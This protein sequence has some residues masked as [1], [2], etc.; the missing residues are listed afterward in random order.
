MLRL[1]SAVAMALFIASGVAQAAED[2]CAA[3]LLPNQTKI[4]ENAHLAVSM[5]DLITEDN[6]SKAKDTFGASFPIAEVPFGADFSSFNES[7]RKYQEL[8]KYDLDYERSYNYATSILGNDQVKAWGECMVGKEK[9]VL[10]AAASDDEKEYAIVQV[11]YD[12]GVA[13]YQQIPISFAALNGE[14][15]GMKLPKTIP[16]RISQEIVISRKDLDKDIVFQVGIGATSRT[17]RIPPPPPPPVAPIC[18]AIVAAEFQTF[19]QDFNRRPIL[20]GGE[21]A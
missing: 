21:D 11:F 9:G 18:P 2:T 5:L 4:Q 15:Q 20:T 8:H 16:Q 13:A 1:V 6:Y 19:T 3:I 14:F 10:R 12:S 7:R 17:V